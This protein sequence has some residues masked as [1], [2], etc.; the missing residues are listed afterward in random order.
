MKSK[1]QPA[2][3]GIEGARVGID[4]GRVIMAPTDAEG[5]ADT[6]FLHGS[7][8]D[9]METPPCDDAFRVIAELV[10]RTKGNVWLV[11]KAGPRIQ[12]LT[13]AWLVHWKFHATTG[14]GPEQVRF[15][16][17]RRDKAVHARQ[18][19]LTHFVDD[20]LDVLEHLRGKVERLYLFG[21]QP[22]RNPRPN[23]PTEVL[24]WLDVERELVPVQA[25]CA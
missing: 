15:C 23:W 18:L 14:V 6:S 4:I 16:R 3:T 10:R 5:R 20:R 11:S 25:N 17:E 24:T 21:H 12:K 2:V 7:E 13:L 1:Q 19:R 8:T 9:A 22:V